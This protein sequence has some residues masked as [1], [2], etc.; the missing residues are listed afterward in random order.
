MTGVQTC[1]LPIFSRQ[2]ERTISLY[3]STAKLAAQGRFFTDDSLL[4]YDI[5]DANVEAQVVP[6]RHFI[7][8]RARLQL[9]IRA[10]G[11]STL[12]LRL[13]EPLEV[14]SVV[15]LEFGRLLHLRVRSQNTIIV[16][17]PTTL[18]QDTDVTLVI[19]YS[20]ILPP[21]DLENEAVQVPIQVPDT[22]PTVVTEPN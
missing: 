12:T 2:R 18:V 5:L 13:A 1:A 16:N 22:L 9:R 17:L 21:Q 19:T 3:P 11:T 20:G 6:D 4:E 14:S 7:Q 8:G 10:G 15:S